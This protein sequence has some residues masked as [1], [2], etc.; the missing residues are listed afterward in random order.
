MDCNPTLFDPLLY[1]R[2]RWLVLSTTK[3]QAIMYLTQTELAKGRALCTKMHSVFVL[4]AGPAMYRFL[5]NEQKRLD[6]DPQ[7]MLMIIQEEARLDMDWID[8]RLAGSAGRVLK[9]RNSPMHLD[10]PDVLVNWKRDLTNLVVFLTLIRKP[11]EA[12]IIKNEIHRF[13]TVSLEYLR[14]LPA[15]YSLHRNVPRST[16]HALFYNVRL[17]EIMAMSLEPGLRNYF[18]KK[19]I[20]GYTGDPHKDL[21]YVRDRIY[22]FPLW[23]N[24]RDN[25]DVVEDSFDGR[26]AV[27][28]VDMQIMKDKRKRRKIPED[29]AELLTEMHEFRSSSD[30]RRASRR[31]L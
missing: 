29:W 25:Q 18:M 2:E 16:R 7:K 14:D 17:F 19:S 30:I 31:Y 10:S 3:P 1:M 4:I 26:Q 5:F 22:T 28:H 12:K 8:S 9:G 13:E 11:K 6:W 27:C 24:G 21:K 23:L 20:Q 15:K